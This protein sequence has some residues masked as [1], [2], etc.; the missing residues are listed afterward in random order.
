VE[1]L[2]HD[3]DYTVDSAVVVARAETTDELK[4]ALLRL[5]LPY[6]AAVVLHDMERLTSAEVAGVQDVSVPAAKQRLR[7]G[8]MML[9]SALAQGAARQAANRGVPMK[10]WDARSL[11]SDYLDNELSDDLRLRVE[12]HLEGCS[13]CPPLYAGLVAATAAVSLLRDSN[14]VI[15]QDLVARIDGRKHAHDANEESREGT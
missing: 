15:P 4:D 10:C 1:A 2:W 6:R 7:R 8:R 11:V 9:V 5:P 3:S 14:A 13:T 12:R